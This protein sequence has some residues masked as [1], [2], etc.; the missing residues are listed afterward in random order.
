ME[1]QQAP[2]TEQ[3]QPAEGAKECYCPVCG[4]KHW[5]PYGR[6]KM[7]HMMHMG[8]WRMMPMGLASMG[9]TLALLG[10]FA[11]VVVGGSCRR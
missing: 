11:G 7:K 3:V 1:Q 10:F 6:M 9:L 5:M 8:P 2:G 4:Q